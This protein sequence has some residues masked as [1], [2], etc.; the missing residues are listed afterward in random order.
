MGPSKL[1]SFDAATLALCQQAFE[2]ALAVLQTRE[3]LHG[4]EPARKL[5]SA[6]VSSSKRSSS[7]RKMASL[8][9]SSMA[10]LQPSST[11]QTGSFDF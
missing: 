11:S 4:P 8:R 9:S 5:R 1:Q 3:W 10:S 7:C 2:D 6:S